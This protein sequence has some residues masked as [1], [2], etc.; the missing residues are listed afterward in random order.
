MRCIKQYVAARK[1]TRMALHA[2]VAHLLPANSPW[3]VCFRLQNIE[4]GRA[5]LDQLHVQAQLVTQDR[6]VSKKKLA[7]SV[8]QV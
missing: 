4:K 3:S 5:M 2:M 7:G 1:C 8:M 6:A